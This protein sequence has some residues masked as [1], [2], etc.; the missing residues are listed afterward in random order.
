[1]LLLFSFEG[2][3]DLLYKWNE[4]KSVVARFRLKPVILVLD[5]EC[6]Q[7][8]PQAYDSTLRTHFE[9]NDEV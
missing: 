5:E 4:R 2:S 6:E 8:V 9:S 3:F 7:D 1:M